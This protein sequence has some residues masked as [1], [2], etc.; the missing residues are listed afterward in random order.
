MFAILNLSHL[1]LGYVVHDASRDPGYWPLGGKN[2]D[3]RFEFL[4]GQSIAE[5]LLSPVTVS[6]IR[7][8]LPQDGES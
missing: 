5:L 7:V 1:L 8:E 2:Y 6:I 4:A 3:I